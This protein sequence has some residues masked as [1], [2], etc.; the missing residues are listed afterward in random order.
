MTGRVLRVALLYWLPVLAYCVFIF[1]QSGG[2]SPIRV[3]LF[4]HQ[5]KVA[6]FLGYGLL[7]ALFVRAFR[8]TWPETG[9]RPL[10]L[11][12]A[13]CAGLYGLTDEFHQSFVAVRSGD[14]A[15]FVADLAGSGAGAWLAAWKGRGRDQIAD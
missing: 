15:D 13:V 7:G 1:L 11:L 14:P 2:A 9:W 3:L 8:G 6:H 5:D 4:P 12:G 10:W